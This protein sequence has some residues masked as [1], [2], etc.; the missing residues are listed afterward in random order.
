MGH[1]REDP[2]RVFSLAVL[3]LAAAVMVTIPV[4]PRAS[5]HGGFELKLDTAEAQT[6]RRARVTARRYDRRAYRYDRG[7]Y[8]GG[9]YGYGSSSYYGSPYYGSSGY[10]GSGY[11]YGGG[12]GRPYYGGVGIGGIEVKVGV[13]GSDQQ[14]AGDSQ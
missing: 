9:G 3:L 6:Y 7:S 14:G 1:N 11:G 10:Y 8:Y 5:T 2:M 13:V 4:S 12:Y